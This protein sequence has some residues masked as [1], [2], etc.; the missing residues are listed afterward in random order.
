MNET[1]KVI[2]ELCRYAITWKSQKQRENLDKF[3]KQYRRYETLIKG[4]TNESRN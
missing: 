2:A 3:I 1:D 4:V